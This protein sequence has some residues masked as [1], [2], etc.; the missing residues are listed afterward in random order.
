MNF[1][2]GDTVMHWSLGLGRITGKELRNITGKREFYYVVRI[3]DLDIWVPADH[4]LEG[5]LRPPTAA[6]A[7]QG[8]FEILS[9]PAQALPSDRRERKSHL[10]TRMGDGN[11]KSLCHVIRDLSTLEQTKP[12]S[13]DD[14]QTLKLARERLLGEWEYSLNISRAQA[15]DDLHQ[16]LK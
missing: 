5:R 4:L 3:Q 14:K 8:L 7:F 13:L 11:V 10:H 1:Q 6:S 15:E 12:L 2:V 16:L 9:G